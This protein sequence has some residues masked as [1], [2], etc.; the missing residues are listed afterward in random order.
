MTIPTALASVASAP[1]SI[2]QYMKGSLYDW[3]EC[4]ERKDS[5]GAACIAY[6]NGLDKDPQELA[7]WLQVAKT[8]KLIFNLSDLDIVKIHR[9]GR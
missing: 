5:F 9:I 3:L 7:I 4:L 1:S 8:K 2:Y 6:N